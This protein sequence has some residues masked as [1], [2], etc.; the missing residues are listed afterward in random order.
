MCKWFRLKKVYNHTGFFAVHT[1][2]HQIFSSFLVKVVLGAQS[3]ACKKP[4]KA[5]FTL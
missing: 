1:Y 5:L 3:K 2:F 4:E